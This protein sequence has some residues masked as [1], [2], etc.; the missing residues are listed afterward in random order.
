[1]A[2]L[3]L[4]EILVNFKTAILTVKFSKGG[5]NILFIPYTLNCTAPQRILNI[6]R[7]DVG[8]KVM[9]SMV[10]FLLN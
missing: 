6:S 3:P 2:F 4:R 8:V 9:F 5:P 1:M 7:G 10:F